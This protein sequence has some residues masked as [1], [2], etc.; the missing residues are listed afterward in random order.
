MPP[1]GHN[2]DYT[3]SGLP[4]NHLKKFAIRNGVAL[5]LRVTAML[6]RNRYA[7]RSVP[8]LMRGMARLKTGRRKPSGPATTVRNLGASWQKGFPSAKQVPIV[9]VTDQTAFGEI[10]TPCPLRGSG[11]TQACWRMMAYDR[12]VV[13]QAGGHFYVLHSQAEPGRTVCEVA[14][15]FAENAFDSVGQP[16]AGQQC[17]A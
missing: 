17:A 15:S 4:M 7:G 6:A 10:H 14:V 5:V 8:A 9:N 2:T 12:E 3:V 13:R 16:P 11:D 1:H